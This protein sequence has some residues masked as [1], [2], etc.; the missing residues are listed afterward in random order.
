MEPL[1]VIYK[2]LM[3]MIQSTDGSD[4]KQYKAL[5]AVGCVF[6][7]IWREG[8]QKAYAVE[9]VGGWVGIDLNFDVAR[10]QLRVGQRDGELVSSL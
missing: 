1:E 3:E 4:T 7:V 10:S 9:E 6:G 5:L 2:A 8:L